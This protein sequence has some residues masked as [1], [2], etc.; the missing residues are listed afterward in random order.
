MLTSFFLYGGLASL[1]LKDLSQNLFNSN[2]I[3]SLKLQVLKLLIYSQNQIVFGEE[4]KYF[5]EMNK[6]LTKIK[7]LN[8]VDMRE[9]SQR[10]LMISIDE[11]FKEELSLLSGI[12]LYIGAIIDVN[13]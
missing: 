13:N 11:G 7:G 6:G 12:D 8:Y 4:S 2:V 3:D 10:K 5:I 9:I 1:F